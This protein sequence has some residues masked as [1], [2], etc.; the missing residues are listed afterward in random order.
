MPTKKLGTTKAPAPAKPAKPPTKSPAK[1]PAK[2]PGSI[3][4][5]GLLSLDEASGAAAL[6]RVRGLMLAEPSGSLSVI[7]FGVR[8][9][10]TSALGLRALIEERGLDR[11]FVALSKAGLFELALLDLLPDLARALWYIR[12]RLDEQVALGSRASLPTDLLDAATMLRRDMLRVLEFRLGDD[13]EVAARLDFIRRGAGH[14]DLADDLVRL[15]GLYSEHQDAL[16]GMPAPFQASDGER[17]SKLAAQILVTL[18][19]QPALEKTGTGTKKAGKDT[20]NWADLQSRAATLLERSYDEIAA[21]GR[22]LCRH[23]P[24]LLGRFGSLGSVARSPRSKT[25]DAE[26]APSP[27]SDAPKP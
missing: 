19:L 1:S 18:G 10:A 21:A 24:D 15:G 9:A 12:H 20:E 26:P 5:A 27:D 11:D 7:H 16:R 14:Q 4:K 3:D 22:Y 13:P 23:K 6:T 25:A 8:L 2:P 17:A